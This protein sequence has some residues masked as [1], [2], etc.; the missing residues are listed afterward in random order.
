MGLVVGRSENLSASARKGRARQGRVA[1]WR[2]RACQ[3]SE[4]LH[5]LKLGMPTLNALD[6]PAL[7]VSIKEVNQV[8][9]EPSWNENC[10]RSE[11]RPQEQED[12][13]FNDHLFTA[14][15]RSYERR[16]ETEM[17]L[18]EYLESCRGDPMCYANA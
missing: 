13:M 2:K 9:R 14:F 12:I 4:H 18:A 16:R 6:R 5:N 7:R 10:I 8:I 3:K 1:A 11:R 15:A 17:S